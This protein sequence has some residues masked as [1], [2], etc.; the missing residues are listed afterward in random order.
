MNDWHA[1]HTLY[2]APEMR[3]EDDNMV[4]Y[5]DEDS[6][7][8]IKNKP[9]IR[10]V[11]SSRKLLIPKMSSNSSKSGSDV[12]AKDPDI[13][14]T[15]RNLSVSFGSAAKS[16]AKPNDI[17]EERCESEVESDSSHSRDPFQASRENVVP[18]DTRK[19]DSNW[20]FVEATEK[21][22]LQAQSSCYSCTADIIDRILDDESNDDVSTIATLESFIGT[23]DTQIP[24]LLLVERCLSTVLPE[25]EEN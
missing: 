25:P 9:L 23:D 12:S 21:K 3:Q 22:T 6:V 4:R 10:N 11:S 1:K 18:S 14:K 13:S 17:P 24:V 16:N 19:E 5:T 15:K 7:E 20:D 2:Q 8:E